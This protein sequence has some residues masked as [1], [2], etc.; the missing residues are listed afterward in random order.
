[1]GDPERAQRFDGGV[2]NVSASP[3]LVFNRRD[4]V[5]YATSSSKA[6]EQGRIR[7]EAPAT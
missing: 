2:W 3:A 5:D 6:P 7:T 4:G 1:M